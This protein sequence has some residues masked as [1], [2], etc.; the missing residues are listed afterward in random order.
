MFPC[1]GYEVD[2]FGTFWRQ[3]YGLIR[4]HDFTNFKRIVTN[5]CGKYLIHLVRSNIILSHFMGWM[6]TKCQISDK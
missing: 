2:A 3:K 6:D 4:I 5:L 1:A